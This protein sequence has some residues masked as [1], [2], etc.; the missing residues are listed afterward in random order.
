MIDSEEDFDA[1]LDDVMDR[2]DKLCP[3]DL[4]TPRKPLVDPE[5]ARPTEIIRGFEKHQVRRDRLV[6]LLAVLNIVP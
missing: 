6:D 5:G 4:L 2:L 3:P 1:W